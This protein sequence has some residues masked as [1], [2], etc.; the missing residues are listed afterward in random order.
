MGH[1][2]EGLDDEP[3]T[4]QLVAASVAAEMCRKLAA[5]GINE[6]HF[7]TLNRAD[8]SFAICHM[9]GIRPNN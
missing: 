8:L 5:G 4:R 9:L 2:F 7:Y 3:Q 6:F 1:M